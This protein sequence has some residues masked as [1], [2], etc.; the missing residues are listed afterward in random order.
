MTKLKTQIGTKKKF[1]RTT[2]TLIV[3]KLENSNSD[4]TQKLNLWSNSETLIVMKLLSCDTNQIVTKIK[5][6]RT[7]L[8][9]NQFDN[10]NCDKT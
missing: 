10:S 8:K 1:H 6:R 3:I 7:K 4:E 5:W 2:Q 9:K